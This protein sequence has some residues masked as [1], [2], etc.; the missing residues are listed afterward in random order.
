MVEIHDFRLS[1]NFCKCVFLN[2]SFKLRLIMRNLILAFV[3]IVL[4][5]GVHA[6]LN[7]YVFER[8]PTESVGK[9]A[10]RVLGDYA[11]EPN[12]THRAI[13]GYWGDES[14][15]KKIMA[16]TGRGFSEYKRSAMVVFQPVGDGKNYV[17]WIYEGIGDIGAYY[18]GVIS[19]FYMDVD[20]S[21]IKELVILEK[22]GDREMVVF[23]EYDDDGELVEFESSACCVDAFN[24]VIIKQV[25]GE[26]DEFL[27]LLEEHELSMYYNFSTAENA[28]QVKEL[29]RNPPSDE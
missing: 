21:G 27:P 9:F 4:V 22:G 20:S 19:L 1:T 2:R 11:A 12:Q 6:Q 28:D 10:S 26:D 3:L 24:T 8:L 5:S 18:E 13:E 16:F 25:Q 14:K 7:S 23:E 17:A 29:I 15:G